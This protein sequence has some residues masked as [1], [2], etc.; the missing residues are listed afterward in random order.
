M[1]GALPRFLPVAVVVEPDRQASSIDPEANLRT[2][3]TKIADHLIGRLDKLLLW[4]LATVSG[5]GG[6]GDE[7][8]KARG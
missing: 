4:K 6:R 2:I 8:Q 7:R 3:L 5:F 1:H